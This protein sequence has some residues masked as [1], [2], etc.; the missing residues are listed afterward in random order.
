[1]PCK[2]LVNK[3]RSLHAAVGCDNNIYI[4]GGYDGVNRKDD[5]FKYNIE[6]NTW[7]TISPSGTPPSVRDRHVSGKFF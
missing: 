5:F 4:F 2:L 1:L 7:T 3:K 6:N